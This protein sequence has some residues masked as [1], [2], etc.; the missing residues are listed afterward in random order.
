LVQRDG[1]VAVVYGVI[2][3]IVDGPYG[4]M[5]S[6]VRTTIRNARSE[7]GNGACHR[8]PRRHRSVR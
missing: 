6:R 3:I 4:Y 5:N 2:G 1:F 8:G 7:E